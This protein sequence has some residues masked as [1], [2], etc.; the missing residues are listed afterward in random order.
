M[1]LSYHAGSEGR[2]TPTAQKNILSASHRGL[3]RATRR[4]LLGLVAGGIAAL[5]IAAGPQA[6]FSQEVQLVKVDVQ[7]VE[8]GYRVS[9]LMGHAVVNG[10]NQHIGKIDDFII[11]HDEGHSLFT[12]LEV[13]GFLGIGSHL[14]AVPYDSLTIDETGNKIAK[15]ELPG[16]SKD[17]LEKLAEF[18]FAG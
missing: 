15:I 17:Q 11:G 9:E 1:K 6:V 5:A 13:G 14:V 7:V 16:G 2:T 18:H 3:S 4:L 12:I 8:H 10:K